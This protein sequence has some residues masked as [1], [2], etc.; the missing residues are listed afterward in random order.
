MV[1]FQKTISEDLVFEGHGLHT[2]RHVVV[3]LRPAPLDSG[4]V[5]FR[6][7]KGG[8][9]SAN[10]SSVSE[11]AFATTLGSNGASVK[12]VEHL[13]AALAGLEIDNLIIE[14]DGPEIPILDGSSAG[15]VDMILGVGITIQSACRSFIKVLR[16]VVFKEG[17]AEISALPYEG[18]KL[19]YHI[20]Y[21]HRLLREQE[22]TL[23]L[24]GEVFAKHLAPART[25][26]FLKDVEHLRS[27]G[28]A[29][30]GS[31]ENA[32]ILSD[33]GVINPSGLRF[34][35]EFIR[36]KMLDFIGDISLVGFPI[37]GHLVASRSGHMANVRFLKKF[38]SSADCW[39][40][41]SG[42]E[43]HAEVAACS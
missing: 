13:L 17:K 5:F 21:N 32:V 36:H 34:E 27:L 9:I 6:A 18:R 23:D 11:T 16:P 38:L 3:R 43:R 14:V 39:Q 41:V 22:M 10:V 19:T 25:F 33:T 40:M 37:Q 4:I 28:F 30:G 8:F 12:T 26:G 2:G 24:D 35:D 7:D 31:L 1:R 29:K 15:F 42:A 20:H